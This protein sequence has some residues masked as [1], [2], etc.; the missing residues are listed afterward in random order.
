M[1]IQSD[2]KHCKEKM[3]PNLCCFSFKI[4][5]QNTTQLIIFANNFSTNNTYNLF[6]FQ[7]L[8][9]ILQL[10]NITFFI[11]FFST[12]ALFVFPIIEVYNICVCVSG[13]EVRVEHPHTYVVKATQ[14]VKGMS[15]VTSIDVQTN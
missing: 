5:L 13:F 14:L 6:L 7:K 1:L 8:L 2:Q 3:M 9:Q 15:V 4:K 12:G 11:L 10:E